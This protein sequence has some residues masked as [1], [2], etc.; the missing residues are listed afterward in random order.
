MGDP[1]VGIRRDKKESRS[2]HRGLRVGISLGVFN[3]LREV[4]DLSYL[5]YFLFKCFDRCFGWVE[6]LN[7]RLIGPK[8]W[9]RIVRIFLSH[10][11]SPRTVCGRCGLLGCE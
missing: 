5:V 1:T 9:D 4:G 3:K 7:D 11:D 10:L 6:A 2:T 8:T